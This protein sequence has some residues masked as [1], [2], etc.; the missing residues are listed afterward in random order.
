LTIVFFP[1][2]NQLQLEN[3]DHLFESGNKITRRVFRAKGGRTVEAVWHQCARGLQA[4]K[5]S[6]GLEGMGK[7][8]VVKE[9]EGV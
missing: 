2:T 9:V 3:V 5:G 8:D 6:D 1:E 7:G 4:K